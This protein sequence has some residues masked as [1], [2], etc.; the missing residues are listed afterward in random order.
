MAATYG[1]GCFSSNKGA[2]ARFAA[3]RRYPR[4]CDHFG[5]FV[6]NALFNAARADPWRHKAIC[7]NAGRSAAAHDDQRQRVEIRGSTMRFARD[8]SNESYW[9]FLPSFFIL[10]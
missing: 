8:P 7:G 5:G 10:I 2:I 3:D 9:P 4:V 1:N 6:V